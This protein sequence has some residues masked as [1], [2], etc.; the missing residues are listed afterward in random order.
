MRLIV[1][2]LPF[3]CFTYF[4]P[5]CLCAVVPMLPINTCEFYLLFVFSAYFDPL[6]CSALKCVLCLILFRLCLDYGQ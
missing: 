4:I 5:D 1:C 6:L 3:I 2:I